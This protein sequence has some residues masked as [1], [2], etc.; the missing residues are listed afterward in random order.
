MGLVDNVKNWIIGIAVKKALQNLVK[1]G[2]SFITSVGVVSL[3]NQYGINIEVNQTALEGGLTA[4]I[5]GLLEMARNFIK[6]KFPAI[7]K[8]L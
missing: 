3:L 8:Y 5:A 7:G 6:I 1:V 4:L 2:V